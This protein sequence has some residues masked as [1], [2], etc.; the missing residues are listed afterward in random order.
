MIAAKGLLCL[1]IAGFSTGVFL[2][3]YGRCFE[4]RALKWLVGSAIA[5]KLALIIVGY[6]L[7]PQMNCNSDAAIYYFPEVQ[8][9]ISGALPNRDYASSYSPLFPVTCMPAFAGW[10]SVGAFVLTMF[11]FESAMLALYLFGRKSNV[12]NSWRVAFLYTCSPISFYWCTLTGYNGTIIAFFALLAL[13]LVERKKDF[14]SAVS[15][16]LGLLCSKL[17]MAL[18][19]PAVVCFERRGQWKRLVWTSLLLAVSLIIQFAMGMDG[20]A[21]IKREANKMT[22]GN[23]WYVLSPWIPA[24]ICDTF[25]WQA[26]PMV[27]TAVV[28]LA[29]LATYLR[30]NFPSGTESQET[31]FDAATAFL[32][33]TNLAFMIFSKKAYTFYWLMALIFILHTLIAS[34]RDRRTIVKWIIPVFF[35]GASTTVEPLLWGIVQTQ[36]SH[37]PQMVVNSLWIIDVLTLACYLYLTVWCFK[38]S[39]DRDRVSWRGEVPIEASSGEVCG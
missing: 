6:S 2:F 26:L 35:L 21:P 32:A 14:S 17:L 1:F 19:Y 23:V 29:M 36:V 28:V 20:F 4:L 12:T 10:R 33:A 39:L 15:L 9:A 27:T 30:R 5:A 24:D 7:F 13:I 38:A 18:S 34:S 25:A 16:V 8:K 37:T 31:R 3:L 22:S 11:V